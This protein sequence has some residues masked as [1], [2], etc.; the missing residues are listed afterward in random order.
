MEKG[1]RD[2][3]QNASR[4]T[5]HEK[6]VFWCIDCQAVLLE[7]GY[8]CVR[9]TTKLF[10]MTTSTIPLRHASFPLTPI[11]ACGVV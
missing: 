8:G 9:R 1:R 7:L 2:A 3:I 11:F 6:Q 5:P 10:L 4:R